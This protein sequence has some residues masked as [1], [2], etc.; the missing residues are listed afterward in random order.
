M[1]ATD[2]IFVD[3]L[4]QI[5]LPGSGM[6]ILQFGEYMGIGLAARG[7]IF[8]RGDALVR[9]DDLAKGRELRIIRSAALPSMFE[10]VGN[11]GKQSKNGEFVAAICSEAMARS[12]AAAESFLEHIPNIAVLSDAPVL[13]KRD[14]KLIEI[15]GY[16]RQAGI[17][18]GGSR[19]PEMATK[20]ARS[21]L[22]RITGDFKFTSDADR[23]RALSLLLAPVFVRGGLLPSSGR[24][25]YHVIEADASQAGKGYL[26]KIL[27]AVHRT[28]PATITQKKSG[29]GGLEESFDTALIR[30]HSIILVD[31]IRGKLDSPR[32]ESFATE[33][34]YMARQ[35][36][37]G[38]V[39][40]DPSRTMVV[41]TSNRAE[42]TIDFANRSCRIGII[43]QV[44]G[45]AF[46][47]YPEGDVLDH[48]RAR[49]SEYL[50]ALHSLVRAWHADGEQRMK[51]T[52]HD[53]WQWAGVTDWIVQR[54]LDMPP[55][56][57]GHREVQRRMATPA[58][59]WIRDVALAVSRAGL[60][61]KVMTA[62]DM[63]DVIADVPTIELPGFREGSDLT[64]EAVRTTVRTAVG[65]KLA[66]VFQNGAGN[67]SVIIDSFVIRKTVE[68]EVNGRD[69]KQYI[70]SA[71]SPGTDQAS[72][73][74]IPLIS[75]ENLSRPAGNVKME[76]L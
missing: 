20:D 64:D 10:G 17:L 44:P 61:D 1:D 56:L 18:A 57:D 36:Y 25:P 62:N 68:P 54:L 30:G 2:K 7:D 48:V 28:L 72:D 22:H 13:I 45:Y 16:D 65:R 40:I 15:V 27:G 21:L 70:F 52:R 69:S 75:G 39:A 42:M 67:N 4:P 53:F 9:L 37:S 8:R 19:T 12:V 26:V 34:N 71:A 60:L 46:Q 76:N 5:A 38:D 59:N 11:L 47:R 74:A 14:G 29:V 31:N 35:P 73:T 3:G 33:A 66:H 51:E 32:L 50:G 49:Q 24:M 6:S 41:F 43:K 55:L 23:S 63:V 58:I